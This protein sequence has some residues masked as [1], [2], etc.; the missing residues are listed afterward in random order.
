[1]LNINQNI[2]S[3]MSWLGLTYSDWA[4]ILFL[5]ALVL[6]IAYAIRRRRVSWQAR[7]L[8]KALRKRNVKA[9]LEYWDG[10][11]HIDIYL[12]ASRLSIEIDG[13]QHYLDPNQLISDARRACSSCYR[14]AL[15]LHIPNLIVEK[16]LGR[17]A[18]TL[19]TAAKKNEYH[20]S[21]LK[22]TSHLAKGY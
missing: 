13:Q 4:I 19:A 20:S 3:I 15:T 17:L 5:T 8:Y 11:K 16:Y 21:R 12:P 1:M 9:K 18:D 22:K 10:H 2:G 14:Q 7:R 6:L